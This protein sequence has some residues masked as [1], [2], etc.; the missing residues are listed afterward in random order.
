MVLFATTDIVFIR[1]SPLRVQP[2]VIESF[3]CDFIATEISGALLMTTNFTFS[4]LKVVLSSEPSTPIRRK[5]GS[6]D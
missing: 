3:A 2:V 6:E 4:M 5:D 1:L